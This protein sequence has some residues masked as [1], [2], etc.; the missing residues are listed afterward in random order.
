MGFIAVVILCGCASG[1]KSTTA[2]RDTAGYRE[3]K[4]MIRGD[5][6]AA[7]RTQ[8]TK[9]KLV[10]YAMCEHFEKEKYTFPGLLQQEVDEFISEKKVPIEVKFEDVAPVIVGAQYTGEEYW[11]AVD[12]FLSDYNRLVLAELKRRKLVQNYTA[13]PSS[14]MRVDSP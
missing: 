10:F 14:P 13:E 8:L 11:L 4:G 5:A 9:G 12:D 6:I 1:L 7:F 2:A 3:A